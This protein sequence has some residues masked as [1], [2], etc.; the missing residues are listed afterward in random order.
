MGSKRNIYLAQ[1]NT[2]YGN[3][4]F[5]PYSVGLLQAYALTVTAIRDAY[6]FRGFVYL[7]ERI[8]DVIARW[9]DN[10]PNVV[11]ISLYIWNARWSLAL[12]KAVKRRWPS[13]LVVLGGPHVPNRSDG[14][15]ESHPY[16]DVLV[17]GE[18]EVTFSEVLQ[19]QAK[20][21]PRL[22]LVA[23]ISFKDANGLTVKT[24]C[25]SRLNDLDVIPSPYLTGLF[26]ELM[27]LPYSWLASSETHRGCPFACT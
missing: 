12:A 9:E 20:E 8:H 3:G 19:V 26:E 17:H 4:A 25:R 22:D 15:F 10:P 24:A 23:G 16:A 13:C 2:S 14:Y 1:S 6:K 27:E 18:G 11:G 5:L 21:Q 7:R